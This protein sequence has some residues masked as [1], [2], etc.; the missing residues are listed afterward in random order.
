[1]D[2]TDQPKEI[3][4]GEELETAKLEAFLKDSISGLEGD[5]NIRQ[6]PG[7]HSNLT[8]HLTVGEREM[9]LRRPPFGTKVKSAH[10]MGREYR[11]LDAVNP[12]YPYAPRPLAYTEDTSIMGCPFYVMER[13]KGVVIRRELPKGLTLTPDQ[14]RELIRNMVQAQYELHALDYRE[15]GLGD[16]GKPQGYLRRQVEGW[17][18]RYRDARTPDAPDGEEVMNWL[19][20]HIPPD[21]GRAALI[22]NDFK[23][24]NMILNEHDP[25]RIVG[26]LDWEMATLGDPVMDLCTSLLYMVDPGD[27]PE[28]KAMSLL[29]S[30]ME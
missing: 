3:R 11:V 16:L 14:V 8:Y 26:V 25:A 9:V 23:L 22:H 15:I 10:D 30:V 21:S 12:V 29:P 4:K 5:L 18:R 20:E 19:E 13:I 27:P 6:F 1:M 17:N 24:D 28:M 2:Y 7:G